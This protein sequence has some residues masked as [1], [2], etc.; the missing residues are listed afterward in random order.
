MA[1]SR[2]LPGSPLGLR[3]GL[4]VHLKF[5]FG[6][7]TVL[8]APLILLLT[9]MALNW[10]MVRTSDLPVA[11]WIGTLGVGFLAGMLVEPILGEALT[12]LHDPG[13]IAVVSVNVVVPSALVA[14]GLGHGA[15]NLRA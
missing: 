7:G 6:L 2:D 12:G 3:T 5:V 11:K 10:W 8:S 1:I 14:L 13:L 9:L 4:P 15:H